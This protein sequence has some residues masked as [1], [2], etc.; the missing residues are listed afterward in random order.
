MNAERTPIREGRGN[1][2]W[3]RRDT[4]TSIFVSFRAISIK[5]P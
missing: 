2:S 5:T 1:A 4:S 3:Y